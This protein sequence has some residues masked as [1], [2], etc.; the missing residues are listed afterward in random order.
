MIIT[1]DQQ[2]H[3]FNFNKSDTHHQRYTRDNIIRIFIFFRQGLLPLLRSFFSSTFS[4]VPTSTIR[5]ITSSCLTIRRRS[6]ITASNSTSDCL[7]RTLRIISNF[8]NSFGTGSTTHLHIITCWCRLGCCRL[9]Q[10]RLLLLIRLP[11]LLG[12][13]MKEQIYRYVPVHLPRNRIAHAE[14]LTRQKPIQQTD[15]MLPL[16]VRWN[17]HIH[18]LQRRIR[19]AQ[20]NNRHVNITTLPHRLTIRSWIRHN[21]QPRLAVLLRDLIRK[22]TGGEASGDTLGTGVVRKFENGAHAVGAGGDGDDVFGFLDGD[23]DACCEDEFFPGFSDVEDVNTVLA[24]APYVVAHGVFR[25]FS[26]GV[27]ASREHHLDVFFLWLEDRGEID[28]RHGVKDLM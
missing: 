4:L 27:Y 7:S 10:F 5:W 6:S 18:V 16:I 21:Q 9:I 26:T 8:G 25:I 11:Q 28:S 19:I 3:G 2:R 14:H 24:T 1:R 22:G 17:C 15:G 12:V 13:T 20:R 23:D